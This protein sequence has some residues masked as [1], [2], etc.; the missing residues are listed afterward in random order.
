[1]QC[2]AGSYWNRQVLIEALHRATF[3]RLPVAVQSLVCERLCLGTA[4]SWSTCALLDDILDQKVSKEGLLCVHLGG[5]R[6]D[7]LI[8]RRGI[9]VHGLALALP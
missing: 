5:L 7:L 2:I 4:I 3:T 9:E 6:L 1:M 8:F